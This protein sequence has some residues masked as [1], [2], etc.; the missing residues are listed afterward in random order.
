MITNQQESTEN[1]TTCVDEG[2]SGV[3]YPAKLDK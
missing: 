3:V 1:S 2:D